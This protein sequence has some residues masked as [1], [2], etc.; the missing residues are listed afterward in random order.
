MYQYDSELNMYAG[1][2]LR[3]IEDW[4]TM[5]REVEPG[6]KPRLDALHRGLLLPLYSRGQTQVRPRSERA[7]PLVTPNC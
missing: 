3:T 1:S 5:G 6:A 2:G 7:E 4:N